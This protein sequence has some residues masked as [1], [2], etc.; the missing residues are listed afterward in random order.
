M[1]PRELGLIGQTIVA[2]KAEVGQ[3]EVEIQLESGAKIRLY[4]RQDCCES[5][6]INDICGNPSD[7]VGEQLYELR[8]Q[9][10]GYDDVDH[11]GSCTW[12]FYMIRTLQ[13]TVTIRWLGES[14]GYYSEEVS[15]EVVMSGGEKPIELELE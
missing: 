15:E 13:S 14:N 7:L 6:A 5:V 11:R 3:D 1:T 12:T 10:G 9:V 4:H 8:K 2:V